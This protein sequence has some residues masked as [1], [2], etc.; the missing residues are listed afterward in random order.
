MGD[1]MIPIPFGDLMEW[2]LEEKKNRGTVFG[3]RRQYQADPGK[4]LTIFGE[5]IETPFGPAAGPNTQLAQ[6]II[7]AYLTGCRFFELKTVQILDG[8]DLPVSKPCILAEDECYNCEWSTELYVQQAYGEYVKAWVAL[9]AL[10]REW[11]TGAEDGFVFNISVGYDLA[12]IQSEK[13]DTYIR[14]M[15]QAKDH[16]VFKESVQWLREN[17]EQFSRLTEADIDSISSEICRSATVSTLHG[18]PP[19]EIESIASYLIKEKGLNTFVKCNPTLLGYDQ[20]RRIMDEM[21]YDYVA[22]GDFHFKD[23][24]QFEDAVPMFR[25]LQQLAASHGLEFGVKI[26]NTFPVDVTRDELPS[27]EMYMSGKS[28]CALSLTTA[29]RLS[30]AFDGRLRISY[31]GGADY[32]NID[33][34]Y[35]LGIWPVTVA[36]TLLKPGGYNRN[37]QMAQKLAS[38]EY[39]PFAGVDVE[40]LARLIQEIEKD[41]HHVK[42]IKPLP[43]RKLDKKV[44]LLDCFIAPCTEGCPIH[45]DIPAYI[46]LAGEG[47]YEEALQVILDKNPLPFMTGTLCNHRCMGK[48][49]RNYYEE[50]VN[51][52]STKLKAAEGGYE[53]VMK[54]L[55]IPENDGK[56]VAV[57][58]AGPAGIA[59]ASFLAR[60]GAQ[61]RVFDRSREPG[62]T[63]RYVI[64]DLRISSAAIARDVELAKAYG[65]Q[66]ENSTEIHS[67]DGLREQGYDAIVLAVGARKGMPIGVDTEREYNAVEFLE[68][69]KADPASLDLGKHVVVIGAGNTAMDAARMAKR[70]RGVEDV[71]VVYRR[72]KRYMPADEEELAEAMEE[73]VLFQELLA[74]KVQKN[75]RLICRRVVL[76]ELDESGRQRPIETDGEVDIPADTIIASLGERVDSAVYERFGIQ[77]GDRGLPVLDPSTME[78]S[79]TGVYAIGDGAGGAATIVLAI[80]DARIAADAILKT[81]GPAPLED[82][83]DIEAAAEKKG[84][85]CHSHEA[86]HERER[87]LEC[88]HI[89][90]NCVDV[91]PNRANVAVQIPGHKMPVIVHVDYMCNECGNCKSFCPYSSAPYQDKFTLFANEGDFEDSGNQGFVV[92][93]HRAMR[94]RVRLEGQTAVYDLKNTSCELEEGLK[95]TILT[96]EQSYSYLYL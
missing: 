13:I 32:Y 22:F 86:S 56:K 11:Q 84:I 72:T 71:T 81:A 9:K 78:T 51:I 5:K 82:I 17:R 2:I 36:T 30:E 76:G 63:V 85:L 88:S 1:R 47:R 95:Q 80:R 24:L 55:G 90:E 61:V 68:T 40:G 38:Q 92:L 74:P 26:T 50:A 28:L 94:V 6:N 23:D 67:L 59:C 52:R 58:G 93:D 48:C 34:I 12:G 89:C 15:I 87:C 46:R 53:A 8:E 64:P 57:V 70:I 41:P 7:A 39:H 65:V 16:P 29:H 10:A 19:Q 37:V 83:C 69:A 3:V 49:T 14:D 75:G 45:Q 27:E 43:S 62:G 96:I 54:K 31:S 21:G 66:F 35:D 33:R 91:C 79:Q 60:A 18:C 25:R 42:P 77:V 20:A 44:P 73:G 4:A